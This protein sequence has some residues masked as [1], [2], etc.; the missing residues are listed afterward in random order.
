MSA[1]SSRSSLAHIAIRGALA[2]IGFTAT[3]SQV[4]LMRE[5]VATFYG[6]EL[7]YGL[8]LMAWLGWVAVGSWGIGRR[9]DR[10]RLDV[11]SFAVVLALTLPLLVLQLALLRGVRTILGVTPGALVEFGSVVAVVLLIPALF[12]P[13]TGF[14][15]TLGVRLLT[16][17]GG[18][19]GQGYVWESIGAVLGG[20][21]VS[22]VFIRWLDPF[23]TILLVGTFSVA[24]AAGLL[25]DSVHRRWQFAWLPLGLLAMIAVP[26]G[27]L[28]NRATLS[29][30]WSDLAF[31]ADSPYGRLAVQA[32]AGQ[33][34]F[35]EN[36]LL[37]F[38]TQSTFPEEVAHFPLLAHPSPHR[39][40]LIGGGVAGDL[41]EI[42]KHPIS[43]VTYVELD[44]L[45]ISTARAYLPSSEAEVLDD[46]RVNLVLSDGRHYVQTAAETFDVVI[47]DLP[48]PSTGSLNRFYTRE[49]FSQVRAVLNPDGIFALGL[50]SAENYWNPELA[51]RNSSVYRTLHAVFADTLT[52]SSGDHMF[53]LASPGVLRAN[54][55]AMTRAL[56]QRGIQTRQVTPGYIE[57]VFAADR[58]GGSQDE[59]QMTTGVR[60]NE[61]LTP[62][63]YYYDLALWLSRFYPDLRG[64]FESASVVN[65]G[66][67][68]PP[69]AV[70][71]L[72]ARW[73]RRWAVPIAVAGVGLAQMM[74]E[75]VILFAFQVVYGTVYAQVSLIVTAFM[76]GL[77]LG[78]AVSNQLLVRWGA[79]QERKIR[80]ALIGAQ[81][82]VAV[83]SG[84]FVLL[85]TLPVPAPEVT[86]ALL[87]LLAGS[88][89]GATFPLA[90]ALVRGGVGMTAGWL[91]GA[92]LV[93]GALGA[94]VC[95]TVL[96]PLLG[97]PQVCAFAALVG[98]AGILAL[99]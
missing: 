69:L 84:I 34:I 67:L 16:E 99:L 27:A 56:S 32:R 40:L 48:P 65:L 85:I 43:S 59:M 20:I 33:R 53:L 22:F 25:L 14:L 82:A 24:V 64:I 54:A 2:T 58:S 41:R 70:V 4:V 88:L 1:K 77:A 98:L 8:A 19:A 31:T 52:L 30:Q 37:A 3:V 90:V 15:F 36:G 11:R 17:R 7:L 9:V 80:L 42:L 86:F 78:G 49:F 51:R 35:F 92:D 44:P 57:Y 89:P 6:N 63:C 72:L 61:D 60:L 47:L 96:V 21:L 55:A 45:V 46:P 93:G 91:Y 97:I 29:W 83:V 68:V 87:A 23:Q 81:A 39:V 26:V 38:E 74:L 75:V 62:I 13:L 5:L 71:V 79:E 28:L 18:T 12:C 50:P 76:A 95:A 73:R 66:W 10:L 94:G